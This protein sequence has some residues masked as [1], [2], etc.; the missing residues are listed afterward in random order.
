MKKYNREEVLKS[1][2]EYFNGDELAAQV[3][4]NKYALKDSDDNIYEL[5][6][7]DMHRRISSELARIEKKYPNPVPENEIFELLKDF[8]YII[9]QGSPMAGIG[10]DIQTVS[11]S[12]C[13]VVGN[14]ADSYGGIMLTD[15]EQAQLMKRRGGVGH[16]LSHIRPKGSPVKNSALTSTGVVPFMERF[17]NTTREVAQDGRRGALMLSISINHPDAVHFID[18]KME[19]GKVTGANVSVKLTDEFMKAA[20]TNSDFIQRYPVDLDFNKDSSIMA[21]DMEY[22]K[23]YKTGTGLYKKINAKKLW[24]KITHNAWSSAEPGLL[25]W[26]TLEREAIPDLYKNHGFKTV[27][28]NPCVVP[29]TLVYTNK[30]WAEIQNLKKY[31]TQYPDLKI[32]TR[33]A[34]HEIFESELKDAFIT[35]K[36]TDLVSIEFSNGQVLEVTPDHKLYREDFSEVEVKNLKSGDKIQGGSNDIT[37]ISVNEMQKK[38]DVWDLT[39]EPNFNFFSILG[40]EETINNDKDLEELDK[41]LFEN[42]ILS[43]DCGEIP[44]CPYD[45]CRLLALNLYSYVNNPF[46]ENAKFDFGLFKKHA[47]I[48]QRFMDDIVDLEI[49]KINTILQKIEND[50]EDETI[51]NI[52]INLWKKI[53]E[54]AVQGRRTGLGITAEGDMIAAMGLRYG[55]DES[56]KLSEK[57]HKTLAVQAYKSSIE[58]ATERGAFQ[59]WDYQTEKDAPFINRILAE[60]DPE[61]I[62]KY[63]N[64]GR[65]NIALLTIAPVGSV[66]IMTKT[67]SGIEPVF[68]PAYTRRRKINPNDK[69]TRTDFI[70]EVGDHW[71]EYNVFHPKFEIWAEINGYN[72]DELKEMKSEDLQEVLKKS[73]YWG[74]TA[75]DVDWVAKVKLQGIVQQF[76]DHSISVTVNLPNHVTEQLVADVYKTGWE[77]GCKGV[78]VYRDGSR[79]GVLIEKKETKREVDITK[80]IKN[81]APKRPKELHCDVHQLTVKGEKWVVFIGILNNDPYEVFSF[82]KNGLT[83]P[84]SVTKGLLIRKKSGVYSF[85][86]PDGL[87]LDNIRNYFDRDE[88]EALTRVVSLSLRHGADVKWVIDQLNKSEGTITSFSKA[89]ARTLKKYLDDSITPKEA[90]CPSCGDPDGLVYEEGCVKCKSCDYSVC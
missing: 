34:E 35:K 68:L 20:T 47:T 69:N 54:K 87:E 86:T 67:S 1:S 51:K 22:D 19:S 63:K 73:P 52:E 32:I 59:V 23:M 38:S 28:T 84:T 16:D 60:L 75:N 40:Y 21:E 90:K 50:P 10:N 2:L 14:E 4:I 27:S 56:I 74:A 53:R 11:L 49:E 17:S 48:A 71:E 66:S 18:A 76:V 43:V 82:K 9:P 61:T 37:V 8:K 64:Y 70:D 7:N 88:Q 57:V 44:L 30:G 33:N 39:A 55:S 72:I 58:M 25:F 81:D 31:K 46:T 24:E 29:D 62:E 79:S 13:F 45:S 65:R 5:S 85:T 89:V 78:T 15:Q 42:S 41:N 12:N 83:L 77:S 6:P 80:I 36:N 26:D 3:W